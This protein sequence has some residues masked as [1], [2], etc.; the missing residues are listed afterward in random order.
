MDPKSWI[1]PSTLCFTSFPFTALNTVIEP[2]LVFELD[3]F[4]IRGSKVEEWKELNHSCRRNQETR[5]QGNKTEALCWLKSVVKVGFWVCFWVTFEML[6]S[7][8]CEVTHMSECDYSRS[9]VWNG[10]RWEKLHLLSQLMPH[11][12]VQSSVSEGFLQLLLHYS[13]R[14]CVLTWDT[15]CINDL[16][17]DI[18]FC[19]LRLMCELHQW[20]PSVRDLQAGLKQPRALALL[21]RWSWARLV[22]SRWGPGLARGFTWTVATLVRLHPWAQL[23][24]KRCDSSTLQKQ[25]GKMDTSTLIHHTCS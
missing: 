24:D 3:L 18:G 6:Q 4:F 2:W 5:C 12:V 7:R 10:W 16:R 8:G 22:R 14:S 25:G 1:L 20:G 17:A 11:L 13:C 19:G 15:F 9:E 21:W 23:P